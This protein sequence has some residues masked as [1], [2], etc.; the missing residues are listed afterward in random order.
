[1]N[2]I[3]PIASGKG[4]VGKTI[5]CANLG[6]ALAAKAKST[7]LV[8]LDLGGSNLH[9][10]L[11]VKNRHDGIGDLIYTK[12]KDL[13][14]GSLIIPTDHHRVFLVPGDCLIPGTANLPSFRKKKLQTDLHSLVS[15][16]V[17]VDLSSGSSYNTIDFFLLSKA[18]V[19]VIT[20]E[21]TAI[22]N[23]YSFLKTA[24]W[25][26]L[27]RSFPAKSA[28]RDLIDEFMSGRIEKN[29]SPL[30]V[31]IEMIRT[32]D[33]RSA[34][35][36]WEQ[37][38]DFTPR[39]IVNEGHSDVDFRI[40]SK[41]REVAQRNLGIR[42]EYI[43]FVPHDPRVPMSIVRRQPAYELL[44]ESAFRKS[45]DDIARRLIA[46]PAGQDPALFEADQ[47]L[48]ELAAERRRAATSSR[49]S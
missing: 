1:M 15:D 21:T 13:T 49:G 45:M 38:R 16:F 44:P 46:A 22:L 18:G 32:V 33:E 6:L 40:V 11:G 34:A 27:Y 39:I 37:L 47:D 9:T 35:H 30:N 2:T 41:L 12:D 23:A 20:P 5:V 3:I 14:V 25:R 29:A 26:L 8:D 10:L 24:V 7:V 17:V 31:L 4:G 43:G 42:I 28:E 36:A 48:R 19:V